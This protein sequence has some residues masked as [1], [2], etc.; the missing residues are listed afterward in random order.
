MNGDVDRRPELRSPPVLAN[1]FLPG[2]ANSTM[3][4]LKYTMDENDDGASP[5]SSATVI[6][7][8]LPTSLG[9]KLTGTWPERG[10]CAPSAP[11]FQEIPESVSGYIALR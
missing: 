1:V 2:I 8:C 3:S 4:E 10:G 5:I 9:R 6:T 7:L 11:L